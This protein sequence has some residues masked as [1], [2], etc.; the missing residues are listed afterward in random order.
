[1]HIADW[2]DTSKYKA[3]LIGVTTRKPPE[4]HS[5]AEKHFTHRFVSVTNID[6]D[7]TD[8]RHSNI[9]MSSFLVSRVAYPRC[10]MMGV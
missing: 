9:I 4:T 7:S 2:L 1:M 6:R 3:V 5:W 10:G 8:G